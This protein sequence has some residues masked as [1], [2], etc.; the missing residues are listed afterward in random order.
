[1][2][3][4]G[5]EE[6]GPLG[7]EPR[8]ARQESLIRQLQGKAAAA[9]LFF[10]AGDLKMTAIAVTAG[11]E[12]EGWLLCDGRAVSRT[13]YADLFAALETTYGAGDGSTTFN[14]PDY[15]GRAPIGAGT[16]SGLTARTLGTAYGA[17][18][19]TLTEAEM[20]AHTHGTGTA[21]RFFLESN[22]TLGVASGAAKFDNTSI[23]ANTASKG[24]GG[25]HANMQ[26]SRAVHFLVKT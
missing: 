17:E 24:G 8:Q 1:M 14:L 11:S 12:P 19:H 3:D 22:N 18:T 25:A 10:D 5:A 4:P 16:G 21:G 2:A 26:P 7:P 9:A 20:P 6:Q 23:S 15:R 13:T